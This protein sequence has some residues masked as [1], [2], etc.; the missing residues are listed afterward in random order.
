MLGLVNKAIENFTLDSYGDQLW[1]EVVQQNSEF[2]PCF[3]LMLKYPDRLTF[4]LCAALAAALNRPQLDVL[5]DLGTYLVS[6]K[7][8]QTLRRL[9]R[10]GGQKYEEFLIS[11][12]ELNER[13]EIALSG[14]ALPALRIERHSGALYHLVVGQGWPGFEAV[15]IGILRALADDYG[16]LVWIE[17]IEPLRAMCRIEIKMLDASFSAG[18]QFTSAAAGAAGG[19]DVGL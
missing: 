19:D 17:P 6:H 4:D 1:Q 18:R 16:A 11:L 10:F 5:E 14:L 13:S 8:G 9:L 15:M 3:E 12:D 2:E 7:N